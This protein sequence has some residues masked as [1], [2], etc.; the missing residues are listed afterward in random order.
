MK[1]V[2]VSVTVAMLL[3]LPLFVFRQS[4]EIAHAQTSVGTGLLENPIK[5]SNFSDFVAAITQTAV[6][7]LM[8]FVV[9]AFIYSGFLFVKAR[10]N[11][12]D[13][14]EAKKAITWSIVGAFILFGAWGFSQIIKTTIS[15]IT[16]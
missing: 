7:I 16:N 6:Q 13:L 10:G 1:K 9:L 2:F 4:L 5:Y 8:P 3:V 14:E 11:E 15:T 12:K